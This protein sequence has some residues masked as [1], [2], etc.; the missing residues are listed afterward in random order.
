M[1]KQRKQMNI[2]CGGSKI[3][4]RPIK[5]ATKKT[6]KKATAKV[7]EDKANVD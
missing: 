1:T 4:E 6:G 7:T 2:K 3:V 5:K